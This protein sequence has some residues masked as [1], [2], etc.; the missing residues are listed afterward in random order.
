MPRKHPSSHWNLNGTARDITA[1]T[2]ASTRQTWPWPV[3]FY[4]LVTA[5]IPNSHLARFN[6]SD[7]LDTYTVHRWEYT[8]TS[9]KHKLQFDTLSV[10]RC[11]RCWKVA[12]AFLRPKA[13]TSYCR[14]WP[15]VTNAEI[16]DGFDRRRGIAFRSQCRERTAI[17]PLCLDTGPNKCLRPWLHV[18]VTPKWPDHKF[19]CASTSTY[20]TH[21]TV[22][23]HQELP[24]GTL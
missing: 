4:K 7:A 19:S 14:K 24:F 1:C 21:S 13:I 6:F 11:A 15:G 18:F 16:S 10:G 8:T 20:C 17:P 23:T 5:A 9:S 2:L 3:C 22:Y 12:G